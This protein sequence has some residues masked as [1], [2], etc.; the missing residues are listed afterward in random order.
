M[1]SAV[2]ECGSQKT[3]KKVLTRKYSSRMRSARLQTILASVATSKCHC[4]R[5]SDKNVWRGLQWWR[6]GPGLGES[7]SYV[8]CPWEWGQCWGWLC[9]VR[10]NTSRVMVTWGALWTEWRTHTTE[11]HYLAATALVGGHNR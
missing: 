10:P 11:K 3:H 7:N 5:S 1:R 6:R 4:G 2:S 9:T 8:W